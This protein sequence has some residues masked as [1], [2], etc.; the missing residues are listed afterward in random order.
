MELLL[1]R[2]E[3]VFV[4]IGLT[5]TVAFLAAF[6]MLNHKPKTT[7]SQFDG[8]E[9][10]NYEMARP[11][12][13]YS[14]Y[15]LNGREIEARYEAS[16]LKVAAKKVAAKSVDK[17]AAKAKPAVA[18][19]K[20]AVA[21][22]APVAP[23]QKAAAVIA[24]KSPST[25]LISS[26]TSPEAISAKPVEFSQSAKPVEI[27]KADEIPNVN[28]AEK[29]RKTF[30][31]WRSEIFAK[32]TKEVIFAFITSH[33]RGDVTATEF[34]AMA[35]DLLDQEGVTLKGLGLMA[36][37]SQPSMASLSQ[38]VHAQEQLTPALQAY[39]EQAYLSYLQP[40][41]VMIFN[42]VFQS[43][44]KKL[45]I[46]SLSILNASIQKIRNGDVAGFLDPRQRRDA[47]VPVLSVDSFKLLLPSL[48]AMGSTQEAD[49]AGLATQVAG[50]IQSAAQV[51]GL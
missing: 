41:Y 42:Q 19:K 13:V 20:A 38:L 31:Q 18:V 2:N 17:A 45:V 30:S 27:V 29:K 49:V 6:N 34:Q 46:K 39:V 48:I 51:A 16:Q 35:Q 40:Q 37:R 7:S 5:I 43:K 47:D 12:Q 9:I 4:G 36:L 8:S 25:P 44:N 14:E 10:I 50:L 32:P 33:R 11:D 26:E 3:K 24:A 21:A 28:P 23:K 15:S 1:T 22:A